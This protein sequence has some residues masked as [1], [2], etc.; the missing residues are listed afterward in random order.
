[1]NTQKKKRSKFIHLINTTV[2]SNC[3]G[4]LLHFSP[5]T[6]PEVNKMQETKRQFKPETE[7]RRK[8]IRKT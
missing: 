6:I 2:V 1:M 5:V 4:F 7:E 3:C 8:K